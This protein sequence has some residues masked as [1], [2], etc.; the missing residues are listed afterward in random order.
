MCFAHPKRFSQLARR[1][2][3]TNTSKHTENTRI[4]LKP[5]F[6][7]STKDYTIIV[8]VLCTEIACCTAKAL[9]PIYRQMCELLGSPMI[10]I[11]Q[12]IVGHFLPHDLHDLSGLFSSKWWGSYSPMIPWSQ[13]LG[14][15]PSYA[16]T[17][18]PHDAATSPT[19]WLSTWQSQL[20]VSAA[21]AADLE[22]PWSKP[23]RPCQVAS[24][25]THIDHCTLP[26]EFIS[27]YARLPLSISAEF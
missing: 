6:I 1:K 16:P 4:P 13:Q 3:R 5:L 18:C 14:E 22:G 25:K 21:S 9:Q 2:Q 10:P 12:D 27:D 24:S 19:F 20:P 7:S 17:F 26:A 8:C 11:F 15:H 23:S